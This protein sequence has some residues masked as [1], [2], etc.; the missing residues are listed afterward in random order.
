MRHFRQCSRQIELVQ[1]RCFRFDLYE[2]RSLGWS[3]S[4]SES[5]QA[6]SI[7]F[8][9]SR[10]LPGQWCCLQCRE[11]FVAR[12]ALHDRAIPCPIWAAKC[13][14]SR[15]MSSPRS[16]SGGISI[17]NTA[18]RKNRSPRNSPF[19]T[20]AFKSLFVAATTR[21]STGNWRPSANPIHH[22]LFDGAQ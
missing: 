3:I 2:P 15:T 6:R 13:L 8:S 4:E 9:S 5:M 10:T 20:A 18:R 1:I 19:S 12:V 7:A 16:R 22:L 14:A 11:C 17:G 21:T